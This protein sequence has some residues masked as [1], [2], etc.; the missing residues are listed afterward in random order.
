MITLSLLKKPTVKKL[1]V[2]E[3]DQELINE[4]SSILDEKHQA[5]WNDNIQSG[6]L[7]VIHADC[8]KPFDSDVLAKI[9]NPDYAWVDT[10]Q[11]LG[12]YTSFDK[13]SFI[14]KQIKAKTI[15]Y[16]GQ[17]L[18]LISR[19]SKVSD[20]SDTDKKKRSQFI[21]VVRDFELPITPK[22]LDK[23]GQAF[24]FEI[25]MLAAINIVMAKQARE[26]K[27]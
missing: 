21:D 3:I 14:Q 11:H 20:G 12:C 7:E 6:R 2:L 16:W 5:L 4:F 10:W 8:E 17:E 22:K 23:K 18:E 13:T 19:L 26:N 25:S 9:K 24:Y 27:K 1:Y 15:D